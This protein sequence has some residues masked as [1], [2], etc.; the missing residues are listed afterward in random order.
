MSICLCIAFKCT[1]LP[2][3]ATQNDLFFFYIKSFLSLFSLICI[4]RTLFAIKSETKGVNLVFMKG[5]CYLNLTKTKK[6]LKTLFDFVR[7][8]VSYRASHTVLHI[9]PISG[10]N[11]PVYMCEQKLLTL[12]NLFLHLFWSKWNEK[13]TQTTTIIA[14]TTSNNMLFF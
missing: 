8:I 9:K 14:A 2:L 10:V 7:L 6:W 3:L 11:K 13:Q 5:L 1:T 4:F 12:Y